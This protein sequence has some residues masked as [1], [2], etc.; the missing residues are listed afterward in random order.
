MR[1]TFEE[2]KEVLRHEGNYVNDSK[3]RVVRRSMVS[4]K[5]RMAM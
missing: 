3:T 4:Q 5:E 1:T 2:I